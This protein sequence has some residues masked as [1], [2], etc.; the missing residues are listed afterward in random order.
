[1]FNNYFKINKNHSHILR[2]MRFKLMPSINEE[3]TMNTYKNEIISTFSI[4]CFTLLVFFLPPM[5]TITLLSVSALAT[6]L[7]MITQKY[8]INYDIDY[9]YWFSFTGQLC[10]LIF[11][12]VSFVAGLSFIANGMV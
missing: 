1:M 7:Y 12:S 6:A 5:I 10:A 3:L 8:D 9:K 2:M 11:V 4:A